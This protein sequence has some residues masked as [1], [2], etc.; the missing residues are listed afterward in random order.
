MSALSLA[1]HR[2]L[3]CQLGHESNLD[4]WCCN[5]NQRPADSYVGA[6]PTTTGYSPDCRWQRHI[7][8]APRGRPTWVPRR[9][10]RSRR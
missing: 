10:C 1:V 6:R 7:R 9:R 4:C 3:S 8:I 5:R 2:W